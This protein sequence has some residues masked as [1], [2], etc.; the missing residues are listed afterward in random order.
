MLDALE[1]FNRALGEISRRHVE[2][3][4]HVRDDPP[5]LTRDDM[6]KVLFIGDE[7]MELRRIADQFFR[8]SQEAMVAIHVAMEHL[9]AFD[10]R[11]A[12]SDE[13]SRTLDAEK[14]ALRRLIDAVGTPNPT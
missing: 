13:I 8:S 10:R 12:Q 1:K 5:T 3:A 7:L 4:K 9:H 2:L 11:E 14:S 6:K